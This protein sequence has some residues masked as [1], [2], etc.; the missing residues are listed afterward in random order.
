MENSSFTCNLIQFCHMGS[1]KKFYQAVPV[2]CVMRSTAGGSPVRTCDR[3]MYHQTSGSWWKT[4]LFLVSHVR[5]CCNIVILS[6][7]TLYTNL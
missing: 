5:T 1:G 6:A 3:A 2:L 7:D 4:V